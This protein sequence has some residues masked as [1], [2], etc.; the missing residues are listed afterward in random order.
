MRNIFFLILVVLGF[1]CQS[2]EMKGSWKVISYEDEIVYYNRSTDSIY[3]KDSLRKNEA[4]NF[5]KMSD[6]LIFSITYFFDDKGN[7]IMNFP[8]MDIIKGKYQFDKPN[9]KLILIDDKGKKDELNCLYK[10]ELLFIEMEMESGYM[11]LG[12]KKS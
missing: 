8:T 7:F 3:Y 4:D 1:N 9:N 2:Q 5:K 11:K 6:M 12:F 10:N